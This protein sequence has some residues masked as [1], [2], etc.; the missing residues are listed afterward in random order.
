MK[1]LLPLASAIAL[2]MAAQAAQAKNITEDGVNYGDLDLGVKV[3]HVIDGKENGFDPNYGTATLLKMKFTSPEWNGLHFAVGAYAV[4]E[5]IGNNAPNTAD[6]DKIASGMFANNYDSM[7]SILGETYLK[8]KAQSFDLFAG[9][10]QYDSPLTTAA[11]ST[12]P[13]FETVIGG[14]FKVNDSLN[15][16]LTQITQ[17]AM[18]A[19]TVTEFGLIGEGTIT[20]GTTFNPDA[21]NEQATFMD[22][23]EITR[24]GG[25]EADNNSGI[26]AISMNYQ[27][28]KSTHIDVWNYY[29]DNITNTFY[30][31]A[32]QGYKLANKTGVK[33]MAQYMNQQDTGNFDTTF[34]REIDYNLLG[35]K[36]VYKAKGWSAYAAMN[37]SS[38][39]T[40]MLNAWGGDPA[41]TSTMF[42]RNAYRENVTAYKVGGMY[43]ITPS[44]ILSAGYANYG[45][46]D[47]KISGGK[48]AASNDAC[49]MDMVLTWKAT[50]S[51]T[52]KLTH[53]KRTS[54]Y[55]D[56]MAM[57]R[58]Q[59]HSRIIL[60][61]KF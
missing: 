24:I 36:A 9:R 11:V 54:E 15:F 17:I 1:K 19:R 34:N 4:G 2:A 47:T 7:E 44:W 3:M 60:D 30:V 21:S 45:Q 51:T 43:K 6:G 26:T 18:G 29:A 12:L 39:D 52:L 49:E 25:T 38:G 50:K 28:T 14:N 35:L 20:G 13:S 59:A 61:W 41:Y 58:T 27:P 48:V 32:S 16:G 10:M 31:E 53:A 33:V 42:S 56:A 46:S 57:D 37:K 5:L 22:I 23:G 40:E 55:D 8:Y